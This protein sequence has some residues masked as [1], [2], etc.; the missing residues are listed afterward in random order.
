MQGWWRRNP[1]FLRYMI[2]EG[3]SVFLAIYAVILLVGLYRLAQGEAAYEAWRQALT[4]TPSIVFHWL[5]LL[6]VGYHAYTW[7]KVAPKTAPDIRIAGR[8]LPEMVITGGGLLA[9]IGTSILVYVIVRW[10]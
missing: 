8:P 1:Y 5:A 3:S 10:M 7:W 2:R 4:S 6:T 9:T